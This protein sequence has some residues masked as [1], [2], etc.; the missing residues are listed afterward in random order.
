MGERTEY[1]WIRY[2]MQ[3]SPAEVG[4]VGGIPVHIRVIGA[5]G[6]VPAAMVELIERLPAPPKPVFQ[7]PAAAQPPARP[8]RS[9]RILWLIGIILLIIVVQFSGRLFDA[10]K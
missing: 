3:I 10:L 8:D 5:G 6:T 1:W 9:G 4:F 7:P 2:D